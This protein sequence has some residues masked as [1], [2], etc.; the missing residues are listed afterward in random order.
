[1]FVTISEKTNKRQLDFN[2]L[3]VT[4]F[5]L[6]MNFSNMVSSIVLITFVIIFG[7][8][9]SKIFFIYRIYDIIW[10]IELLKQNVKNI[11][12]LLQ[13]SILSLFQLN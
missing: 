7:L 8:L 4:Q 13:Y 1:M 5:T 11:N 6:I 3:H 10:I 9:I 12:L 2:F